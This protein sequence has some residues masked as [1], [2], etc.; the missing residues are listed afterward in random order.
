MDSGQGDVAMVG[1]ST[2]DASRV[3]TWNSATLTQH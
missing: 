1:V 3:L 2:V